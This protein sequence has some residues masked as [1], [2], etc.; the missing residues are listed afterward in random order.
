MVDSDAAR[1]RR[2]VF[3]VTES[4]VRI[5]GEARPH[6]LTALRASHPGVTPATGGDL[7]P[8]RSRT[9]TVPVTANYFVTQ[10]I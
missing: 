7:E 5:D 4:L 8:Y 1:W 6:E 9:G 10:P 3:D 2:W